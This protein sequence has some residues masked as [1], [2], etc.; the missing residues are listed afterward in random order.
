MDE[1]NQQPFLH[2]RG[3]SKTRI[4]RRSSNPC[5]Y[6]T[7]QGD[8]MVHKDGLREGWEATEGTISMASHV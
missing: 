2:T 5:K 3:A 4:S 6:Q 8:R 1:D 7:K